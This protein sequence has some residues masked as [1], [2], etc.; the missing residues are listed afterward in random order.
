MKDTV[1]G[2]YTVSV[3]IGDNLE[4]DSSNSILMNANDQVMY[5]C[6]M[7]R[8]DPNLSGGYNA[9]GISQG[10]LLMR[11]VAQRCPQLPIRNLITLG[12]PHQGV[13]GIPE[14]RATLGSF[15]LCEIVRRLL[16]Q[17]AYHPWIQ[18]NKIQVYIQ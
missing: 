1:P 17:G 6:N 14:C 2:V 15:A 12:S 3:M 18:G 7:I 9:L 10:G 11:G 5:V 13:F 8:S 16:T 4:Q